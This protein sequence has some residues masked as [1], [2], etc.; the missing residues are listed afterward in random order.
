[1][2]LQRISSIRPLALVIPGNFEPTARVLAQID[3]NLSRISLL[4]LEDTH[5][6]LVARAD[7]GKFVVLN[8]HCVFLGGVASEGFQEDFGSC[9]VCC[10][11]FGFVQNGYYFVEGVGCCS[12]MGRD[13][14]LL[15]YLR[16]H[17]H[18]RLNRLD[19]LYRLIGL[20]RLN[21]LIGLGYIIIVVSRQYQP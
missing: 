14:R 11:G 7:K 21:R 3:N 1:M 18:L 8:V 12:E 19:R 10:Q 16:L 2:S 4:I 9:F 15:C 5:A 6:S 13:F 17:G 20:D